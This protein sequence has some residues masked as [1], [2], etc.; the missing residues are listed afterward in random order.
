MGRGDISYATG[1]IAEWVM[2][3]IETTELGDAVG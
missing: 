1:D 2:G 3:M